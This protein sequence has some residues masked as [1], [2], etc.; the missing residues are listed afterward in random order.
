MLKIGIVGAGGRMGHALI[1]TV[2]AAPDLVLAGALVRKGSAQAGRDAGELVGA[3]ATGVVLGSDLHAVLA[4]ADVLVD[5]STPETTATLLDA[6]VET[7][8]PLVIGVTG[9]DAALNRRIVTAGARIA[10]VR[11]ANMSLGVNLLL[12]LAQQVAATLDDGFDIEISEA[13]HRHKKDAPSGT[14]LALGEAVAAGR[15]VTLDTHA[16]Y[17]R[18]GKHGERAAGS[19]GFNSVRAGEIV[20]DHSVLFAGPG[21]RIELTHRAESRAAFAR[22]ALAAARW[23]HGRPAGLYGMAEVLG[24]AAGK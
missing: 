10:I 19:I 18:A 4:A 17:G 23:L 21:E 1:E 6:C 16:V 5:F 24:L 22:G 13:H 11:A 3:A 9:M 20:G 12:Q 7:Q 8:T 2:L 15:G 14:A